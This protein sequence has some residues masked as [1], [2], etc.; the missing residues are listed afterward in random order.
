M[1]FLFFLSE[2]NNEGVST[3]DADPALVSMIILE[4]MTVIV[5]SLS[6]GCLVSD[7]LLQSENLMTLTENDIK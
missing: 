1:L 4:Q 6:T 3:I 7:A 2:A 5:R